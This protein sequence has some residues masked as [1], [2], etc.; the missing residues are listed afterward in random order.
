MTLAHLINLGNFKWEMFVW[1]I[2]ARVYLGNQKYCRVSIRSI[3]TPL[4]TF[5]ESH[6]LIFQS[7]TSA[8][9]VILLNPQLF[10][11]RN[12]PHH[13]HQTLCYFVGSSQSSPNTR[14][15]VSLQVRAAFLPNFDLQPIPDRLPGK[16]LVDDNN[17]YEWEVM[18]IGSVQIPSKLFITLTRFDRPPDTL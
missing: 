2:W 1:H 6:S 13:N 17:L 9:S 5:L 8:L 3:P 18:I 16:G 14:L 4:S 10:W 12:H 15:K 11:C 7:F